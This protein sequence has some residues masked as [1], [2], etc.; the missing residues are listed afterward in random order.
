MGGTRRQGRRLHRSRGGHRRGSR[1]PLRGGGGAGRRRRRLAGVHELAAELGD[2][3][4][5]QSPTCARG[6]GTWRRRPP[7]SSDGVAST[8]SSAMPASPWRHP[9]GADP[10]RAADRRLRR[11]DGVNVLA[12]MLG[13]RACLDQLIAARGAVILTGSFASTNAAGGGALLHGLQ[14]RG[15]RA[16]P[17]AGLRVAPTSGSTASPPAWP[18]P[19]CAGPRRSARRSATRCSTARSGRCRCRR[20]R[21][22]MPTHGVFTLLASAG[23]AAMTGTWSRWTAGCRSGASRGRAVV[24]TWRHRKAGRRWSR[25]PGVASGRPS[26]RRC[27]RPGP[28][29][30]SAAANPARSRSPSPPS[31]RGVLPRRGVRRGLGLRGGEGGAPSAAGQVD[32]L[33]NNAGGFVRS[34]TTADSPRPSGRS[35]CGPT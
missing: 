1:P 9:A 35:N 18:R 23:A 31:G 30:S 29:C 16:H 22:W 10:R 6:R 7:R 26:P 34:A 4:V 2:A 14:A 17:P 24:L 11:A 19:G 20:C 25:G 13:V 8:C 3:V 27:S 32:V 21:R 15:A 5:P 28:G 12:P 33:V